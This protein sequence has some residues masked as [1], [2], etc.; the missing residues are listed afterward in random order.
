MKKIYYLVLFIISFGKGFSQNCISLGCAASQTGIITDGTLADSGPATGLGCYNGNVYKQVFWQFFFSPA[1]G[2]F[3]QTYTP[4]SGTTMAINYDILDIGTSPAPSIDCPV[5][6]ATWTSVACDINDHINMPVGPGLFGVTLTTVAGHYYAVAIIIWQGTSNGA[7]A[8]Y[9]FDISTPQIGG[10]DFTTANCPGVLP[11]KLS[12]FNAA[13]N[14]CIVDL[15]WT[16]ESESDFKNY[17]VQY[18][19]NGTSFQTIAAIARAVQ[20]SGQ[21]YTWQHKTPTQGNIYYRLKMI[22][23][24]GGFAYSK[25]ISIKLDCSRSSVII[26]PNPVTDILNVNI[27]S[28]QN[29]LTTIASLFDTNGKLIYSGE[30]ANG[31]NIIDMAKFAKGVYLLKL[32]NSVETQDIKVIK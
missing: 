21:K 11:V 22:S 18:S 28:L 12:S 7:D 30:M 16:A 14:N 4:T 5:N 6:S 17:E 10:V 20:A 13:V 9:T 26:Y 8:S 1:G 19:T 3:T 29:N 25:I 24:D 31:T 15:R 27:A 23:M 32:K 2:D